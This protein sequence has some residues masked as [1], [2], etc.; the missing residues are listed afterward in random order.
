MIPKNI[1][2]EINQL[3]K[4]H[5]H[6]EEEAWKDEEYVINRE[7]IDKLYD[8]T[9]VEDSHNWTAEELAFYIS[10]MQRCLQLIERR[11]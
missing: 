5:Q 8:V 7:M 9:D 1:M 6:I 3:I 4:I 2:H 11:D 10:G